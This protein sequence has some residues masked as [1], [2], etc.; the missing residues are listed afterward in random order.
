M[1]LLALAAL[2][3]AGCDS[4][5]TKQESQFR[6]LT[7]TWEVVD[8]RVNDTSYTT[9]VTTRYDSLQV[10]F[11]DRTGTTYR[12]RGTQDESLR[13]NRSGGVQIF[14]GR[15]LALSGGL[16]A[17]VLLTYDVTQSQRAT[18]TVPPRSDAGSDALLRALL[19]EQSWAESQRIEIRAERL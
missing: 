11:D 7:G 16:D 8:L 12:L 9:E 10:S 13:L 2:I 17:P 4:E 14:D 18:F 5:A 6:A 3:G 15:R 19:P 1:I